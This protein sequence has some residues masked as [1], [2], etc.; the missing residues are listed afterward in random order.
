VPS[1]IEQIHFKNDLSQLIFLNP[2]W[3]TCGL[4]A[5]LSDKNAKLEK[6]YFCK[7]WIFAFWA[8]HEKK[9]EFYHV[10]LR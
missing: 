2:N 3:I 9:M 1:K 4:Y 5:A 10:S 7:Q 6:G 8:E